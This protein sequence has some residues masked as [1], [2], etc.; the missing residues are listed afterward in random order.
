MILKYTDTLIIQRKYKMSIDYSK[1]PMKLDVYELFPNCENII[2]RLPTYTAKV[3]LDSTSIGYLK[4]S[5]YGIVKDPIDDECVLCLE[6]YIDDSPVIV[7]YMK[8]DVYNLE[9]DEPITEKDIK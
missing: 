3:Y 9:L 6:K 8:S 1:I 7:R 2:Q 4:I 5:V